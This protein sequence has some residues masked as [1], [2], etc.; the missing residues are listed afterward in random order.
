MITPK[1]APLVAISYAHGPR[2]QVCL[3]L[4][5]RLRAMG[6][7]C[8]I[9]VYEDAPAEGW[10][11]WMTRMM[12]ERVVLMVC[13][14][15]YYRRFHGQ[16]DPGV[17]LGVTFESGLLVRRFVESQGR[18]DFLYPLLHDG[19]DSRWIPEFLKDTARFRI[20]DEYEQL[21]RVL[22]K[23]PKHPRP[24]L[25]HIVHL[26]ARNTEQIEAAA[27]SHAASRRGPILSH[28]RLGQDCP[29][30]LRLRPAD[31]QAA[32]ARLDHDGRCQP[33]DR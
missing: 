29:G 25:G 31:P 12:S 3:D 16:S 22:T 1:P 23:Q 32:G 11:R 10:G 2:D 17:G 21:Y 33:C 6:V 15:T 20:P 8:E 13:D 19:D 4:A 28:A 7:D 18:N 30:K 14:E 27:G 24:P 26:D 9:D 5:D